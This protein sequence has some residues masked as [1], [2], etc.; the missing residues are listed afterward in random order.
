LPALH[1]I[2]IRLFNQIFFDLPQFGQLVPHLNALESPTRLRITH[3]AELVSLLFLPEV[4]HPSR[5]ICS[6][7]TSCRRFDW[8]LSFVVQI[9]G[10]LPHLLSRVSHVTIETNQGMPTGKEDMDSTQWLELFQSFTHVKE[11]RVVDEELVSGV[12]EALVTE[13]TATG[14]LLPELSDL[15]LQNLSRFPLASVAAEQFVSM[16]SHSGR[17]VSLTGRGKLLF[18]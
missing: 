16:R 11:V 14:I 5:R 13:A 15:H 12:I 18:P 9:L 6:F 7:E 3:S 17:P 2:T 10:H 1:N 4:G 8:Q